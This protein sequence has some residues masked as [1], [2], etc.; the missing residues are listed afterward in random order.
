MEAAYPVH[1]SSN[2]VRLRIPARRH[3]GVWFSAVAA[4]LSTQPDVRAVRTDADR[5][6]LTLQLQAS[7]ANTALARVEPALAAARIRLTGLPPS[8]RRP[9]GASRNDSKRVNGAPL[10]RPGALRADR[11][12]LA[13]G[14]LLLLLTRSLLRSGW[15]APALALAWFLWESFPALRRSLSDRR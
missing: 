2:R 10:G 1:T 12:T 7:A 13:L 15:L 5:A 14:V 3:D 4:A 11:R 9:Y 6:S 8:G